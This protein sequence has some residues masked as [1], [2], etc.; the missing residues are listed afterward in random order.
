MRLDSWNC[1]VAPLLSN[2]SDSKYST[3][4]ICGLALN[5]AVASRSQPARCSAPQARAMPY[6][7][8]IAGLFGCAAANRR[9]GMSIAP[10]ELNLE[11]A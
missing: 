1:W 5:V 3:A 7:P 2:G 10:I 6:S 11:P 4:R 9:N 8:I